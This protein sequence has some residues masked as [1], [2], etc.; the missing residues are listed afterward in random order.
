MP[1]LD[2]L[3]RIDDLREIWKH[4][5]QDF[6]KWLAEEENLKELSD[7]IGISIVL[8]ERES[9]VGSFSVDLFATEEGSG[10]KVVIENQLADTDHDHLGKIITY[11]AGKS[12]DFIIWIV[13]KARDEHRQAIEWL[14]QR[15][16]E[17]IGFFLIEIELWKIGDS[18]PAPKF[19]VV[20]KPNDWAKTMKAVEGL[21][22]TQRLQYEFWQA[23]NEYAYNKIEFSSQFSKRKPQPQH[24]HD[25]SL[26][27]S[28][29]H[30]CLTANTQKKQL[31]VD[32]YIDDNKDLFEKFKMQ[33]TEIV[34]F[35][36]MQVE[37]REAKKACRIIS[38]TNGDIK[39]S[40]D[41]W[42]SY[43]DWFCNAAIKYKE[44]S[45]KFDI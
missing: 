18:L 45:K 29:Y 38:L 35:L 20:E 34:K 10:R 3:K 23:F 30:L 43:F 16:D 1:K 7:A 19:N 4:E 41:S 9:S 27:N 5:A 31:G 8:N 2:K 28:E 22:E 33:S 21:S 40:T 11:A 12:A 44:M 14:N 39:K 6:S 32:I 25:L 36:G 15:T 17:N 13:K 42:E 37:W 26:G 24:W